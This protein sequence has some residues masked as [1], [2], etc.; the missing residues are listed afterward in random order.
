MAVTAKWYTK[1][2]V[3]A[4]GG[5]T[6]G[7][8]PIID[9][10]S[11]S[12]KVML[13]T[14]SYSPNRD[15]HEFKSHITN[16]VTGTGY[17]AGGA[18]LGTKTLVVSSSSMKFDAADTQWAGSTITAR[19]AV[20]YD[21]SPST[22]ATKPLL[23]YID[24]G[25][26][27]ASSGTTFKIAW[28][29]DGILRVDPEASLGTIPTRWYTQA[30]VNAFGT[31]SSA[32]APLF[33]YLSDD[34]K[35]ML[36][37][38]TY[39]PD[40]NGHDF[41]DHVSAYE[42]PPGGNYVTGG[43][44]LGGKSIIVDQNSHSVKFDADDTQWTNSTITGARYAIIYN[45][46]PSGNNEKPLLGYIDFVTDRSSNGTTFKISWDSTGLLRINPEV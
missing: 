39:S 28:H 6:A 34:I 4:F 17:D 44:M 7:E 25:T 5:D 31:S 36:C 37:T 46:S 30:F 11:D 38:S 33:D 42:I 26:N 8:Q 45:D 23:G 1:A 16:E 43:V 40:R 12:I 3:N 29:A 21:D 24:F 20:I 27:M 18:T 2:F 10:L 32:G 35:V 41:R 15:T 13:C 9:L 22:D 14:S 19:Y